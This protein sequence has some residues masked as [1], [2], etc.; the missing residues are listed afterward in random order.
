MWISHDSVRIHM[1]A[2]LL[3]AFLVHQG[4]N[5]WFW[6]HTVSLEVV[7]TVSTKPRY[8][9][10]KVSMSR[11]A[12]KLH[13]GCTGC[14]TCNGYWSLSLDTWAAILTVWRIC[15]GRCVSILHD[16]QMVFTCCWV[17]SC[18]HWCTVLDW[19]LGMLLRAGVAAS[20]CPGFGSIPVYTYPNGKSALT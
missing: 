8:T 2:S 19:H 18:E 14:V 4:E 12:C 17:F 20:D 16:M 7:N 3:T 9:K 6:N 1:A 11:N 15:K 10:I 5:W 13:E